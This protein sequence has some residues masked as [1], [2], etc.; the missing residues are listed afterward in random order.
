[1]EK[2]RLGRERERESESE[3]E[4]KEMLVERD[5]MISN[6]GGWIRETREEE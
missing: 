2:L 5:E 4:R 3:S 1:M 6:G